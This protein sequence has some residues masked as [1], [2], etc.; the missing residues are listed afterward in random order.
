MLGSGRWPNPA[1]CGYARRRQAICGRATGAHGGWATGQR[2]RKV[3]LMVTSTAGPST[4]VA[5]SDDPDVLGERFADA[6]SLVRHTRALRPDPP[7][8]PVHPP[9]AP[10]R[11][12]RARRRRLGG[13][14]DRRIAARRR[15][16]PG[17]P[18]PA[19]GH[20]SPL[21]RR[22]H[23]DRR[24]LHR[25]LR[26]SATAVAHAQGARHRVPAE[27]VCERYARV[28]RRQ[29]R[30]RPVAV[31]RGPFTE[32]SRRRPG[33]PQSCAATDPLRNWSLV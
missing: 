13:R 18:P 33:R 19:V 28:A 22:G 2:T 12:A 3:G 7:W 14:G 11:G 10:G 30:Q 4:A 16:G 5:T 9:S 29:G 8:P 24:L 25:F 31:G 23:R 6:L 32:G 17:W 1:M 15:R 21:R 20:P 26:G 27:L